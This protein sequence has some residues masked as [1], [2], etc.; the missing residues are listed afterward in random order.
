MLGI[1]GYLPQWQCGL[2]TI[3]G[4]HAA[5]LRSLV[6]LKLTRVWLAW[7][8]ADDEWF[9]DYPVLLDFEGTQLEIC[10]QKFD[11]LSLTWNTINPST[12]PAS[13]TTWRRDA[14]PRTAHLVGQ[15]LQSIDLLEWTTL[16]AAAGMIAPTFVF[17]TGRLTIHNALDENALSFTTPDPAYQPHRIT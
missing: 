9:S 17:P 2:T 5:R 8:L 7:D 10:H 13:P 11:D 14:D 4:T 6:N 16:D 15:P 12:P 1:D 3:R